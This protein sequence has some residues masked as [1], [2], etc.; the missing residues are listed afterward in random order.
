MTLERIAMLTV[1]T[2]AVL[3][4]ASTAPTGLLPAVAA[5]IGVGTIHHLT[6]PGL[7]L[8]PVPVETV[9]HRRRG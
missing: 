3:V 5:M 7:A 1:A 8:R 2:L 9:E 6:R 4:L